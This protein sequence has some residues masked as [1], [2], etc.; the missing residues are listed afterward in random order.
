MAKKSTLVSFLK[1]KWINAI[2]NTITV[3]VYPFIEFED[4]IYVVMHRNQINIKLNK[5]RSGYPEQK[6]FINWNL[7]SIAS[8]LKPW[9]TK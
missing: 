4:E 3:R 7:F 8:L 5:G 6:V 1:R 9:K 2:G